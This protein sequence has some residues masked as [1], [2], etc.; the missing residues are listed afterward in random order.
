M[1]GEF[2]GRDT[3]PRV[4]PRRTMTVAP[5]IV[6]APNQSTAARPARMGVL[7]VWILRMKRIIRN[8]APVIGTKYT[9]LEKEQKELRHRNSY[10]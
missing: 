9:Q 8:A 2:H 5:T 3:P 4:R 10:N 7:G 6:T 1:I